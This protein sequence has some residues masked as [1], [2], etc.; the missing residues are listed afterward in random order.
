M[1]LSVS[2]LANEDLAAY[3]S[4]DDVDLYEYYLADEW[5]GER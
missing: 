3:N 4:T 5:Q 1:R 2:I